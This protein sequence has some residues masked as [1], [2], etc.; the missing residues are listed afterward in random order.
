MADKLSKRERAKVLSLLENGSSQRAVA[1]ECKISVSTVNIVAK[2]KKEAGMSDKEMDKRMA[3]S[4]KQF[5]PKP[6]EG[7]VSA[8]LDML[9][10]MWEDA[11]PT[12]LANASPGLTIGWQMAWHARN[13]R[14][15][16]LYTLGKDDGSL[17][18]AMAMARAEGWLAWVDMGSP[19]VSYWIA[20]KG[21]AGIAG[22]RR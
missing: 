3:D 21:A 20:G 22:K 1:R 6:C 7:T 17:R 12:E 8:L 9:R 15:D 18:E 5:S 13:T 11:E 2:T 10:E 19:D 4:L 14:R 16:S